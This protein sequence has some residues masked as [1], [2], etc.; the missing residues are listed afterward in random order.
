M[1]RMISDSDHIVS[2][3]NSMFES[4]E[5]VFKIYEQ[6]AGL[7]V[8]TV[9]TREQSQVLATSLTSQLNPD[10]MYLFVLGFLEGARL[11]FHYTRPT[12][13]IAMKE[14]YQKHGRRPR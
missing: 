11:Y 4:T 5:R 3:M 8:L 13:C 6:E 1:P 7:Y 10:E 9:R 14:Y 2:Q 12:R